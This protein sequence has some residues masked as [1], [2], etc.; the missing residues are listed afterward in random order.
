[1][2]GIPHGVQNKKRHRASWDEEEEERAAAAR[3][4]KARRE[5]PEGEALVAPQLMGLNRS[6][7]KK[8]KKKEGLSAPTPSPVKKRGGISVSRLNMLARPKAR[9]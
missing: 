9:N 7:E 6:P 8:Q 2:S 5:V 4:K 1:M 3:A